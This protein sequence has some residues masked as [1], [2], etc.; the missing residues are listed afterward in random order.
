[1]R[2]SLRAA[3]ATLLLLLPA[4]VLAQPR[5]LDEIVAVVGSK[6]IFRSEVDGL[7]YR[8]AAQRQLAPSDELW[9]RLLSDVVDQSVLAITA[10]RDTTIEVSDAEVNQGVESRVDQI[11]QQVGGRSRIPTVFGRSEA[12]LRTELRPQ[13][14]EQIYADR[15]RRRFMQGVRISPTEVRAWLARIPV[16]SLPVIPTTARVAHIVR[17]IEPSEA[18]R[19]QAFQA[20]TAIRDSIASGRSTF[21]SMAIRF[22]DDPGSGRLGGNLGEQ[23]LNI[24]VPEFRAVAA[25]TPVGEVSQPFRTQ[26]GYHILRVLS[27]NGDRA[28][29]QHILL[30]I[31][32]GGVNPAPL[33][34]YLNTVRDSLLAGA[35]FERLARTHSQDSSSS[36]IGGRVVDPQSGQRDLVLAALGPQWT[37]VVDTMREGQISRPAR[38]DLLDG[39]PAYHIVLLQKRTPEHRVSVESDYNEIMAQAL[40]EKQFIDLDAYVQRLRHEVYVEYRGKARDLAARFASSAQR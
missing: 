19:Q 13:V 14:R 35:P 33:I 6:P 32:S 15:L 16:D 29:V 17:R 4:A 20:I 39:S 22:S 38:V 24:Y 25:S 31:S 5:V 8:T 36:V 26:F 30:R 9:W 34:A 10:E 7:T 28:D 12:Q 37:T 21:E 40:R 18:A 2:L 1:M 23:N 3:L 27:R 11:A